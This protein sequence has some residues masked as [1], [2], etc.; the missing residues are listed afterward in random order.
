MSKFP[1]A[2]QLYSVRDDME[3]DFEGTLKKVADLDYDGVEFAGLF[4]REPAEVRRLCEELGLTP[5]STHVP[6][7]ELI[8]D[9]AETVRYYKQLGVDYIVIPYLTEDLRPGQ[10]GFDGVITGAA[11]IGAECAAENLVLLYH[12]HDFEFVKIDGQYALD[13]LYG[14]IPADLLQTEI[15]TCWANVG[16]VDPSG[17]IVK[18][19]DRSPVIHLKDFVMPGKKPA[20]MYAL[21]GI[22]DTN[23]QSSGEAAFEFRPIGYGVQDIEAIIEASRK[24]G[25]RWLIVEQD[26]PSMGRTPMEC[27]AMSIDFLKKVNL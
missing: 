2:L 23:D 21:I 25:A 17:Y 7:Q 15:D 18:Y 24:A 6:Y 11:V 12:N 26:M 4:G 8:V 13:V 19:S 1:I 10:P 20:R 5:V 16:G 27:A 14:S 22:D 3:K 9:P